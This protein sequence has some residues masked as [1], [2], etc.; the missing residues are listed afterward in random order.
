MLNEVKSHRI[1]PSSP[2]LGKWAICKA[3]CQKIFYLEVFFVFI[4]GLKSGTIWGEGGV[5]GEG[6]AG[7]KKVDFLNLTT[8]TNPLPLNKSNFWPILW[9]KKDQISCAASASPFT[10]WLCNGLDF[11]HKNTK[12]ILAGKFRKSCSNNYSNCLI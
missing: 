3:P 7:H 8:L 6:G 2:D 4:S 12:E 5:E 11:I 9:L 1:I 10:P